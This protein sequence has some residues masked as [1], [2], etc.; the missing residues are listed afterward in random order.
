[1]RPVLTLTGAMGAALFLLSIFFDPRPVDTQGNPERPDESVTRGI[2]PDILSVLRRSCFD[3]HS[4][5]TQWP[6]YSRFLPISLLLAHD[7]RSGREVLN[8]SRPGRDSR[9]ST[10]DPS[11]LMVACEVVRA[12]MMPPWRYRILHPR[13][14]IDGLEQSRLCSWAENQSRN[15]RHSDNHR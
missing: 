14:K 8:F 4:N 1:M 12:G 6:W 3:C 10:D 13:A 2:P 7:V 5:E 15:S 9:G 11:D